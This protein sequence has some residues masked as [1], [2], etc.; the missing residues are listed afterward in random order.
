MAFLFN[1]ALFF[2]KAQSPSKA[3]WPPLFYTF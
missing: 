2:N 3:Q 1:E